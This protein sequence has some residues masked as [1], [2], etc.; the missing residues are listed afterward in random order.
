MLI[1][2]CIWKKIIA[3]KYFY[4]CHELFLYVSFK[5]TNFN[6]VKQKEHTRYISVWKFQPIISK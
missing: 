6:K 2:I 3:L 1:R 4:E 5:I